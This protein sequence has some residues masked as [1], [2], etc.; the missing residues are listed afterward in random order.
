MIR[1]STIFFCLLLAAAA[2]GRY[3]AEATVRADRQA[4]EKLE[5]EIRA[6][7]QEISALQMQ[8][9]VLESGPRLAELAYSELNLRAVAPDQLTRTD[10]FARLAGIAVEAPAERRYRPGS[11]FIINAIAMADYE[12]MPC[13]GAES[14][15]PCASR[16]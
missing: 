12:N 7:E 13:T 6:E 4:I 8:V 11:D 15:F 9:E 16:D 5:Q 14:L 1:I 10:E 2:A 3:R